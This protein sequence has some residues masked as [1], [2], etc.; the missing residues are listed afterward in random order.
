MDAGGQPTEVLADGERTGAEPLGNAPRPETPVEF[1]DYWL[2]E[3]IGRGGM[4]VVYKARQKRLDRAVAIKIILAGSWASPEQVSRF[5]VEAR[6]AAAISHPNVVKVFDTGEVHGQHFLSM[7]YVAGT[8]LAERIAAGPMHSRDAARLARAVAAA[9]DHLHRNGIVHRDLK[10]TNILID[11]EGNPFLTDFGLARVFGQECMTKT[12]VIAGTPWYM[13]PEQA[14]GKLSQLDGRSDIYSLGAI[15]YER[16]TGQPP[17]VADTPMDALVQVIEREPLPPRRIN[18]HIPRELELIC[19]TC[20][21]KRPEDRYPDAASLGEDLDRFVAGEPVTA[22]APRLVQRIVRW[23]R[24]EPP[25]AMRLAGIGMFYVVELA[26]YHVFGIIPRDFYYSTTLVLALWVLVSIGLQQLLLRERWE[27]AAVLAWGIVDVAAVTRILFIADGA[28]SP[29]IVA[30]PL[31]VAASGL[32]FRRWFVWV[33]TAASAA[34]YLLLVADY[35]F[36]RTWLQANFHRRLDAHVYFVLM[37]VLIGTAAAYQVSRAQALSR[38]YAS[39]RRP[40]ASSSAGD[41][42]ESR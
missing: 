34:S 13:S 20:L 2:L 24:R 3:E 27:T 15:L 29:L 40:W 26:N 16:L 35:Y 37:L 11:G 9:L 25:L 42:K 7:E 23:A 8:S 1:G 4:G 17:C 38:Y 14:A 18:P 28:A 19:L 12:S 5:R 6:A 21:A 22:T 39:R 10:P 36:W 33:M 31:L 32:W 30:Y 41:R